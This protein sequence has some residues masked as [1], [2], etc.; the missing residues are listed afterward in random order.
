MQ[1]LASSCRGGGGRAWTGGSTGTGW[2]RR[3]TG[4]AGPCTRSSRE[5]RSTTGCSACAAVKA[6][7]PEDGRGGHERRVLK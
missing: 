5:C 1:T 7:A 6:V 3:A 2:S 4:E